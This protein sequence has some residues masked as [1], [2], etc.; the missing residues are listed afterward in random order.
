MFCGRVPCVCQRPRASKNYTGK[1]F[2]D[3]VSL[4]PHISEFHRTGSIMQIEVIRSAEQWAA[5]AGEWQA[6][7]LQSH[8]NNP[9]LTYEFQRAWF[10][11]KGGGEWPELEL[12]ILAAR[13]DT[14]ELVGIA[15]LFRFGDALH[16]IGTHEI[17]DFLDF[18]ARDQDLT[19]FIDVVLDHLATQDDWHSLDLYNLLSTSRT[20][21]LLRAAAD[22][23]G[24]SASEA[25]LQPSPYLD[26]PASLE[27]YAE[28]LGSKQGHELRRKMRRASR[29]PEPISLEIID[30]EDGLEPAITDFFGLMTQEMDKVNFLTSPMRHQMEAI[31][32][33]AAEGGWLQMAFL[34]AGDSRIAGYLNFDY[35][36]RIWA[37]NA[38]FNNAYASLSPGWLIMAEMVGWCAEHGR[39][40]FDFMRGGEEYKYRFGGKDRFV[41]RLTITRSS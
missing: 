27:A 4:T 8:Q 14:G 1:I 41:E 12:Y 39:E 22:A 11:H 36:N 31:I 25:T 40:V 13:S 16:L 7:L 19:A 2:K 28:S 18:I 3:F 23:R 35:D 37:Y 15:P 24:W 34:R 17:A 32:R 33:A 21:T 20:Q 9:F 5:L 6:L 26:V 38:G 29:N 10:E 30:G